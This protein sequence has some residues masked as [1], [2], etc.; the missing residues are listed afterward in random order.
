MKRSLIS[1]YDIADYKNLAIAAV[2]ARKGKQFRCYA[3]SFFKDFDYNISILRKDI[4][5]QS[6]PYG[7]FKEFIIY[8]PKERTINAAC[9]E[10]RIIHHAL[11]NFMEPVFEKALLPSVFAC[12]KGKGTLAAVESVQQNIRRYPW[13]VKIDI[14]KYFDSIDHSI[15][16]AL[17]NK[18]FKG[19]G[20]IRLI[21]KIINSYHG[22]TGKGLPIG[23][24]TSQ[25][26]A[27]YY[28][29]PVDRFITEAL[30]ARAHTRYMDDIIWWCG[31]SLECKDIL[32]KVQEF[33]KE[34]C[35]LTV[36]NNIQINKSIKGVS[37]CGFRILPGVLRLSK[38][39]KTRYKALLDKWEGLYKKGN[40]NSEKL[41]I[42]YDAV[43][44]VILHADS[45][46]WR[47]NIISHKSIMEV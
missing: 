28:L 18:K 30:K 38:R 25:H 10:D 6:A 13:Y 33:L 8:D 12:R 45:R 27:N 16:L 32:K 24:L 14:K 21:C 44:S 7:L 37:F 46:N 1:L 3:K 35:K 22:D 40:I 20:A 43:H 17:L 11:I 31:S 9:F 39:R 34:K 41:Q 23:S 19:D 47:R 2:K 15:L 5:S 42:A 4:L 26:F 36:K 29:N